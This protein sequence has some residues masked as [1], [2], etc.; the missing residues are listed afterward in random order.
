MQ[1]TL[2][3]VRDG[4][5]FHDNISR[6]GCFLCVFAG[7]ICLLTPAIFYGVRIDRG[8]SE[9]EQEDLKIMKEAEQQETSRQQFVQGGPRGGAL[10]DSN[11][12]EENAAAQHGMEGKKQG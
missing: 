2:G 3:D 8:L 12:H 4:V 7:T 1:A 9:L 11:D 10:E 6:L 5:V